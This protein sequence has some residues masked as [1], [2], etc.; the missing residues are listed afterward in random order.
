MF[1]FTDDERRI[2]SGD[3]TTDA[4]GRE[5]L[6]GLTLEETAE[7]IEDARNFLAGKRGS[8]RQEER[9]LELHEKHHR[10]LIG[11]VVGENQLR[12]DKPTRH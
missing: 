10:A 2:H 12:I 8:P 7:F 5:I 3:I 4:Q 11:V 1:T 9:Y 6:V